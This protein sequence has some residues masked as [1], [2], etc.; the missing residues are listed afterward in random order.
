MVR[1][2]T[3]ETGP[4]TFTPP[5]RA[6]KGA[7]PCLPD[8]TAVLYVALSVIIMAY[9]SL[10]TVFPILAFLLLWF[11]HILYKGVYILRPS[12]ALFAALIFPLLSCYSA[13]WSDYPLTTF[14]HGM[15]LLTLAVSTIIMMRIVRIKPF[16]KGILLG[17]AII[18]GITLASGNYAED[19]LSKDRSLMGLFGSKNEVGF[20]S[21]IGIYLSL[22]MLLGRTTFFE[23]ITFSIF[24]LVLCSACLALS[25]SATSVASLAILLS[26]GTAAY[27][28]TRIPRRLR[29]LAL[30]GA[31]FVLVTGGLFI[32]TA[33][34]DILNATL[35]ALGKSPTLTGR[36][37]LWAE[38]LKNG[39]EH[40]LLGYGYSAFWVP[41]RPQ[42]EQY[43]YEFYIP[44]K[45]G[46][47]FHNLFI[48]TFVDLGL[49][50][51]LLMAW[52]LLANSGRGIGLIWRR[53]VTLESGLVFGLSL[54]FLL[55]ACFEVDLLGPYGMGPLLFFSLFSIPEA[56]SLR[57]NTSD[58]SKIED[59]FIGEPNLSKNV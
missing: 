14:Y 34:F 36:T 56:E 55:R 1:E 45:T 12:A 54:L 21:E 43:W 47:H 42:A 27:M 26:L 16:I 7:F 44:D 59:G 49:A 6:T 30:T 37:Y 3:L 29:T 11:R 41:G 23:K 38:G 57:N 48:Q 25:K 53:G 39:M 2:E 46:F 31:I 50:G 22:L 18:M 20:F 8:G 40:P 24:P 52:M 4:V 33:Q 35:D 10:F 19:Y 13:F 9:S 15:E 28:L 58:C 5:R 51:A 32:A 17:I